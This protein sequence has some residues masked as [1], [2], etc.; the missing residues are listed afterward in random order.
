MSV[1]VDKREEAFTQLGSAFRGIMGALRRLR[2]RDT[3]RPGELSY[4]QFHLLFGL[5]GDCALSTSQLAAAADL[6]PATVTQ[7][8]DGLVAMGLVERTRSETD[9]RVVTCELT[10]RG[11]ELIAEKRAHWEGRWRTALADFSTEE[12]AAAAAV[13]ERLREMY[14]QL[15]NDH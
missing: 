14:D 3:H 15:E 12:L 1:T 13:L 11:R 5:A 6:S 9:R 7:M 8:L 10:D 2:G 4:A